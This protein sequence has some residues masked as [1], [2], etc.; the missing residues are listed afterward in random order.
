M[1][2]KTLVGVALIVLGILV[3]ASDSLVSSNATH[4]LSLVP[5][6]GALALAGGFAL[7]I[8]D[9]RHP[10]DAAARGE[11]TSKATR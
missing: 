4:R 6:V 9:G 1:R 8:V 5:I 10:T 11:A 7:M 3:F 2:H